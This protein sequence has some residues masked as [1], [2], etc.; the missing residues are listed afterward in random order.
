MPAAQ[1]RGADVAGLELSC[2]RLSCILLTYWDFREKALRGRMNLNKRSKFPGRRHR[3]VAAVALCPLL[4]GLPCVARGL[5]ISNK[6]SPR[7]HERPERKSTEYIVLH[8]TEG[9]EKGSLKKIYRNG[10]AHYFV[11]RDG[12]VFRIIDKNRVAFH[13]G[14][15]M[16]DGRTGLDDYSVGIEISGYHNKD[17][18]GAQYASIKELVAQLQRIYRIPDRRVLT[19]SMIAYGTPNRWHREPHRGRKRC[20]MLFAKKN[21][22]RRL[23]LRDE[24]GYDPDVREG[25]LVVADP[26]LARVLYGSISDQE[27]A[28]A[29]FAG[30]DANSISPGRSAWDIARDR[31]ASEETIYVFP[32]GEKSRGNEIEDWQ[33]IPSGTEVILSESQRENELEGYTKVKDQGISAK[34]VAGAEF[35]AESTIYL[36]PGGRVKTG[37][38]LE[39]EAAAQLPEG[40]IVLTGYVYGGYITAGRNA[41]DVCG[42]HWNFPDTLY[43]MSD[44]RLMRGN[45][46]AENAIPKGTLVFFRR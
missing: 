41:F 8:T 29:R 40:T 33:R 5:D 26:Y 17:I 23:G 45:E 7:N 46:I 6:I 14:K 35:N 22:R 16:W 28:V 27:A 11:C 18:T 37:K 43:R 12:H 30:R 21:V 15:S 25:R 36:F 19:H 1:K 20:G 34:E 3:L 4:A 9:G 42:E 31:Y 13:A 38:R 39:P 10:E 24:P 44:G 32:N 2:E